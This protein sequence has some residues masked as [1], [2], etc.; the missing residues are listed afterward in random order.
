MGKDAFARLVCILCDSGRL[1]DTCFSTVEEQVAKFLNIIGH[2][3][4]NYS[5]KLDYWRSKETVSRHFH[6]VLKAIISLESIF[7]KQADGSEC[8]PEIANSS[9]FFPYFKV[10]V[11]K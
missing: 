9:R 7:L 2:N 3:R 5:V 10:N 6:N 1:R 11:Q 4:R 8:P